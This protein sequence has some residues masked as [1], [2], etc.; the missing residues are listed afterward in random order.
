MYISR[1]KAVEGTLLPAVRREILRLDPELPLFDTHTMENRLATSLVR[2][3]APMLL[4]L[5]FAGIAL[6]LSAIGIYGVLAYA[7]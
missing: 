1:S 2:R 3:K 6:L 7:V 4:L 5:I